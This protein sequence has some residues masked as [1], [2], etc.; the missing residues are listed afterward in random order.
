MKIPKVKDENFYKRYLVILA[1]RKKARI[2]TIYLGDFEDEGEKIIAEEVPQKVKAEGFSPG[3]IGRHIHEHL[4]R[5]LKEIG[6]KTWEYLVEK[7][8]NQLDG[9]FIGT[10]KELYLEVRKHL[11]KKLQHKVLGEFIMEPN[12]ALGDITIEIISRFDL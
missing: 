10:H 3:R 11:P 8:I 12:T 1:D 9:I 6:K 4:C 5:H 7:K 2:F